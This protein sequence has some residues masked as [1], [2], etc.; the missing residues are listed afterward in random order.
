MV[1]SVN[2]KKKVSFKVTTNDIS[3]YQYVKLF[4]EK[5]IK[6]SYCKYSETYNNKNI[7]FNDFNDFNYK[8]FIKKNEELY[9]IY[10]RKKRAL[11]IITNT[12]ITFKKKTSIEEYFYRYYRDKI[13]HKSI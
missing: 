10:K 1:I 7:D 11:Q 8:E 2:N 3:E 5:E 4:L 13:Y 12:E 6:E 9:K